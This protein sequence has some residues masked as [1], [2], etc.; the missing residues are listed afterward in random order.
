MQYHTS[1]FFLLSNPNSVAIRL[2]IQDADKWSVMEEHAARPLNKRHSILTLQVVKLEN[3][4]SGFR[5]GKKNIDLT[6]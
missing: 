6:F 3:L 2:Q 5:M 4:W 1:V